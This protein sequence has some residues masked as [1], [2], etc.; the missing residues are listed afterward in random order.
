MLLDVGLAISITLSVLILMT[1]LFIDTP[2]D[3]SVFPTMLLIA[4]MMRLALNVASTRL[5][6]THGHEGTHA[7]GDVIEAFGEFVIGGNFV[8]GVV[9][10]LI[11]VIINFVVITKG[12]GPHRRG[13]GALQPRRDARQADGDRRRPRRRH[14]RR[15]RGARAPQGARGRGGFYGAMDGASKFVRGDAI[16][17]LLV[18]VIN[19]VGGIIIGIVQQGMPFADAARTYT[20]LTVGDGLVTQIPALIVSTAAGLL[21]TKAGISG[22]ADRRWWRSSPAIPRRSACRAR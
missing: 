18:I 5:I 6:L 8:V 12:A 2:L 9:V 19:I 10:F 20:M 22:S 17:G 14:H 7:A 13:R 16:A 3:F 4:T 15:D 11:L 1:A 21:V